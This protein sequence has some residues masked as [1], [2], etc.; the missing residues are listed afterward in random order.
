M[1][2]FPRGED[3][4]R[5]RRGGAPRR[6]HP[7]E[8]S[9]G[10]PDVI[11]IGTGSEVQLAV[12]ARE[13]L[14]AAGVATRVVSA[15]S[16]EWFA[17]QDQAYREQVLPPARARVSVEGR[18]R[19]VVAPDHRRRRPQRRP[20][21]ITAPPPTTRPSTA[22]SASP[23]T[24]SSPPHTESIAAATTDRGPETAQPDTPTQSGTGDRAD[25]DPPPGRARGEGSS[26]STQHA[27]HEPRPTST[28]RTP[29]AELSAQGVA[30]WLDDLSRELL[31][32]G[33]SQRSS[34]AGT[35]SA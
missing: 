13:T 15:P 28:A 32:S 29:L 14:E 2:T 11:L 26:L 23:P 30:V 9:T 12:A 31:A 34:R 35:S 4:L 21:N 6:V 17:E 10:T 18:H 3:G 19:D 1:P 25:P 33:G 5:L 8:A 24:P 20:S 27:L 16:L 22:S 7:A